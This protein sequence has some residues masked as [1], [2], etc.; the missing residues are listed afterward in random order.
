MLCDLLCVFEVFNVQKGKKSG[1]GDVL[2]RFGGCGTPVK[3][4]SAGSAWLGGA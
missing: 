3:S 1:V 4:S 2:A